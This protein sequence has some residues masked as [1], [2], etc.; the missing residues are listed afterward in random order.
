MKAIIGR[1]CRSSNAGAQGIL[2]DRSISPGPQAELSERQ[3]QRIFRLVGWHG[4]G[5]DPADGDPD[6]CIGITDEELDQW[7]QKQREAVA[8]ES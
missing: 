6:A 4:H 1:I 8:R 5:S 3:V 2:P 7:I